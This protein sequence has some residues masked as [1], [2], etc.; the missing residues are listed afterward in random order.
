MNFNSKTKY[1]VILSE[2]ASAA[3]PRPAPIAGY[4]TFR[5]G[6]YSMT[7]KGAPDVLLPRCTHVV[8][9]A[10]A[11]PVALNHEARQRLVAIQERWAG[12]GR[13]VLVLA[14]RVVPAE[15]IPKGAMPNSDA[16]ED[17][18]QSLV[19]DLVVVGLVG[20]IDPLKHDIPETVRIVRGAGVRF[21]VVTGASL[22]SI[23]SRSRN[24]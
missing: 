12:Q 17:A 5:A 23:P 20:L 24:S 18:V 16:F 1:M 15:A 4:E 22:G 6:D 3:N 9:A 7:I 19:G 13:R 10:G 2:P 11:P 8:T 14:R 21:F